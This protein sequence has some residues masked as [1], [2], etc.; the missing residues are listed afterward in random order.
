MESRLGRLAVEAL[1]PRFCVSCKKEGSL[2]CR[3]CLDHWMPIGI[4]A[5][6]PF[7]GRLGSNRTCLSCR[8]DRYLDGV[9]SFISYGNPIFRE[10]LTHW[11]Y[12]GDRSVEPIFLTSVRKAIHRLEPP[13]APYWISYIP[14]HI[15]RARSRGFDQSYQIALWMADVFGLPIEPLVHRVHRTA[16]QAQTPHG[17]RNVGE[18]D[19]S[20]KVVP[21]TF[22]P[23]HVLLCD[24]V[25]TS[26]TTMD[27]VARLLK[28]HGAKTVWGVT[29]AKGS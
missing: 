1:F 3:K 15:S 16:P 7:C 14:L 2:M 21:Q 11:K 23:E 22:V 9:C 12:H 18:M 28:T 25:F 13:L 17:E 29:L 19:H 10:L 8:E 26:G 27:A 20:F 24:D 6:C 5:A 4:K